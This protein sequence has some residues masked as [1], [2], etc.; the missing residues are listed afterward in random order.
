MTA[1][2]L[3][4]AM[5]PAQ[6]R[7]GY[8]GKK[9]KAIVTTEVTIPSDAG[10]WSGGTRDTYQ[11]V[12]LSTGTAVAASDNMSSPWN[13]SRRDQQI[14][15]LPGTAI[16]EH[17]LFCGK[18]MGLTFYVHP[19]NAAKLL[20]A[21]AAALSD[22]E[23]IVLNATCSYKS[24]Y[25]GRDRYDMAKGYSYGESSEYFPTRAQWDHAKN[26]LIVKGLLTKNGAV[27]PQGRNARTR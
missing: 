21:P 11:F 10:L 23:S 26:E 15:L 12:L 22:H 24:S 14:T 27:T 9:F 2:Y 13:P 19:D 20:P 16:V 25:N 5:V 1:I 4:P 8:T 18:D 6:L 7:A 3:D 17:S